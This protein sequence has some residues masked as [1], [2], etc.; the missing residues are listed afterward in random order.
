MGRRRPTHAVGD[1]T[2]N[3]DRGPD[4]RFLKPVIRQTP[5]TGKRIAAHFGEMH[6]GG[7]A[8]R[9]EGKHQF[10]VVAIGRMVARSSAMC[11]GSP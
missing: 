3:L 8:C 7:H 6:S 9:R 1:Q 5:G 2:A 10:F 4:P 11:S